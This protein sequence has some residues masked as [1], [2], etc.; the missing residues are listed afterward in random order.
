MEC[1]EFRQRDVDVNNVVD[2]S[3]DEA[4]QIA[5]PALR[6]RR[7]SSAIRVVP[8]ICDGN[9]G[10]ELESDGLKQMVVR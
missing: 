4:A 9:N 10:M 3:L 2:T 1:D 6:A 5:L 7:P 8:V